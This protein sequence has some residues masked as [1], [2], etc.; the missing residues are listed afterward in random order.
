MSE[1]SIESVTKLNNLFAPIFVN[2]CTLPDV[3]FNGHWLIN[4]DI[5]IPKKVINIYI[6]YILNQ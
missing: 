4:N 1:E 6:F 2:H 5:S 3:N